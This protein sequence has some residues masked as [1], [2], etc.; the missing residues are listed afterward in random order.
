MKRVTWVIVLLVLVFLGANGRLPNATTVHAQTTDPQAYFNALLQRTEYWKSW[1][2]RSASQLTWQSQGG[3]IACSATGCPD[4][5]I[6]YS[7]STDNDSHAQDAAKVRIPAF[8]QVPGGGGVLSKT[9]SS[10]SS[11]P[12][13][14]WVYLK[15]VTS[16]Y[17]D[18]QMKIDNEILTIPFYQPGTSLPA[19]DTANGRVYVQR[20]QFGTSPASHA[21]GALS[22]LSN[23]GIGQSQVYLPLGTDDGHSYLFTWDAYFTDSWL[24]NG[25][26]NL[27]TFNLTSPGFGVSQWAEVDTRFSDGSSVCTYSP[28]FTK[29]VD[30][31]T[32]GMR[33]YNNIA[34][35]NG[36]WSS[37]DGNRLK[38]T[39]GATLNNPV[40]P[41]AQTFVIKPNRWIRYWVVVKQVAN[42]YDPLDMWIADE[43]TA[44]VHVYVNVPKSLRTGGVR[45]FWAEFNT[46]TNPFVR[47][48]QRDFVTYIRN[49]VA[50]RDVSYPEGL[51]VKP[52]GTATLT[53]SSSTGAPKPPSNLRIVS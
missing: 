41:I 18:R 39:Y 8:L 2:L 16:G 49:F 21:A 4:Q 11:D 24:N 17:I 36:D 20:G 19:Y 25:L 10:N 52:D 37:T 31:G 53:N 23:N 43:V 47:G 3:V 50:L 32:I 5:L 1:S 45:E 30:V 46:S 44:P 15:T 34:T 51:M 12:D 29:G 9:L 40:C 27:K 14:N 42:D 38:G 26:A 28:F 48:S 22:L 35:P 7:P 13:Y 6:T 33:T